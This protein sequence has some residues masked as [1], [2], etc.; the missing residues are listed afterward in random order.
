M[1]ADEVW[2][3]DYEADNPFDIA[4]PSGRDEIIMHM[5]GELN[6]TPIRAYSL[7]V[8]EQ[9]FVASV[10]RRFETG[11]V[12]TDRQFETLERIYAEKTA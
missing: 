6:A 5:L 3:T 9:D 12:L 8:W 1:T 2:R 10:S 7:T 11:G 4:D